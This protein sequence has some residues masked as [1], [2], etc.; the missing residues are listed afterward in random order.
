VNESK[1]PEAPR[2]RSASW[3]TLPATLTFAAAHLAVSCLCLVR[4]HAAD[5][6]SAFDIFS[7]GYL[8]IKF[9]GSTHSLYSGREAFRSEALKQEWWGTTSD[10]NIVRSTQLLM[11]ADLL[12]FFDY[13]H[14]QTLHWLAR[15][16]LQAFGLAVYV[17][18]KIW[19]VW[20]D[21]CLADYF[22]RQRKSQAQTLMNQG[23]FRFIRHPRYAGV[24]A[25]KVGCALIFASV[26]GWLLAFA[27]ALVYMQNV[28]REETHMRR[29]LGT[30]YREY[31]RKTT[32][33]I[34]WIY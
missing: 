19:Q 9:L 16:A 18:A 23:P 26:F 24:I 31:S 27:W 7:G 13:G 21:A 2:R 10:P 20:T 1:Q 8:I 6:W 14:W 30:R 22:A 32:R 15:P 29:M 34:P 33:L 11:I 25:G 28:A 5:H 3:T 4:W 12:I 17:F